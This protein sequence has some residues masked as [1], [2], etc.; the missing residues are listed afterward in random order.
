MNDL[1]LP[2]PSAQRPETL[3]LF[4]ALAPSSHNTQPWLFDVEGERIRLLA[5]RRHQ[6]QVC[7]PDG[8]ELII[9]CGCALLN[10]R[11]AIAE[12]GCH[13]EITLLPDPE[14]PD[15]L[16]EV[17]ITAD[18]DA[19]D[20]ELALLFS[21]IFPR[22]TF[23]KRFEERSVPSSLLRRL[24]VV[25][26]DEGARFTVLSGE[27]QRQAAANLVAQGDEQQWADTEW[28]REL[29][30]WMHERRRGDGLVIPRFTETITHAIV[31]S[32]DMGNGVAARDRELVD[33]SP[34]LAVVGTDDDT[35]RAWLQAGMA[36]E[37]LLLMAQ[38]EG[39]QASYLNQAIQVPTLRP[40][41][42]GLIG[43][44]GHPQVLI[45]MGYA[46]ELLAP[47]P[48]RMPH[49]FVRHKR[50]PLFE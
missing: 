38:L 3:L 34:V 22:R 25:A 20:R 9:S 2:R 24:E 47:T 41:L 28:R 27:D 19:T 50:R 36:L 14:N 17:V 46:R 8:R 23:R 26:G 44:D 48:R 6:L 18:E 37:H 35:P 11:V 33:G 12:A 4:A 39:V 10:L 13:G 7:D 43:G 45:R 29:S 42:Q 31:R 5:D 32:F 15:L 49:E 16:A 21:A 1:P 30:D 40:Q